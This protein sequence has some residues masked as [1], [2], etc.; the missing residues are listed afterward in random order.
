MSFEKLPPL[1]PDEYHLYAT[2]KRQRRNVETIAQGLAN[3]IALL[4]HTETKALTNLTKTQ[5]RNHALLRGRDWSF[6]QNEHEPAPTK[7]EREHEIRLARERSQKRR[8]R[9]LSLVAKRKH[10]TYQ[11]IKEE[12]SF[13]KSKKHELELRRQFDNQLR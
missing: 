5:K 11:A 10:E 4:K 12:E 8:Q 13:L 9:A 7:E 6:S 1:S 3:R 2:A